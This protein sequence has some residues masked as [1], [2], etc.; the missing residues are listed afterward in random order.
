MNEIVELRFPHF[1]LRLGTPL[2]TPSSA[3]P[4]WGIAH[5]SEHEFQRLVSLSEDAYCCEWQATTA[6]Q[7]ADITAAAKVA[8]LGGANQRLNA[9]VADIAVGLVQRSQEDPIRILDLGAG[10]GGTT[11]AI[12]KRLP[13][14]LRIRT[15]WT[16]LDPAEHAL[17]QAL[18]ALLDLGVKPRQVAIEPERDLDGLRRHRRTYDLVVGTAAV[19]HH[20]YLDPVF[21]LVANSMKPSAFLVIGDWH[22]HLS[23]HPALILS[24]M[25][26]LTWAGKGADLAAFLTR[27]PAAAR[28]P[29]KRM[30]PAQRHANMQITAFWL[31]Y[32]QRPHPP[33]RE[34]LVLEGHRPI[35]DYVRC[36]QRAGLRVPRRLPG[37]RGPNPRFILPRSELLAVLV[38]QEPQFDCDCGRKAC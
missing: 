21:A 6:A 34:F 15:H 19:H 26:Q 38:A 4:A 14:N 24:L 17:R 3:W 28:W 1:P 8:G 13:R 37:Q 29:R 2:R 30:T 16:L 32:A 33:G 36:L 18:T 22:N 25:Q 7:H 35:R 20:A 12:W 23:T 11:I 10:A 9:S 27:Y 31:A 5:C